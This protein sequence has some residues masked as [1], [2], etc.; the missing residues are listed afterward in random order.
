MGGTSLLD[1]FGTYS[2]PLGKHYVSYGHSCTPFSHFPVKLNNTNNNLVLCSA[3]I[4][5]ACGYTL[6]SNFQRNKIKLIYQLL[7]C[8]SYGHF[9][10]HPTRAQCWEINYSQSWADNKYFKLQEFKFTNSPSGMQPGMP[11]AILMCKRLMS[12]VYF[13]YVRN[14]RTE[15]P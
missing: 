5:G 14:W 15:C 9:N 8:V 2:S 1:D 6:K 4:L 12:K 11:H 13:Q 3:C 7:I 10:Y